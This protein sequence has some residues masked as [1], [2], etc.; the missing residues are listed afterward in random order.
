L[1][2]SSFLFVACTAPEPESRLKPP[3][4]DPGDDDDDDSGSVE[5]S[6]PET[7]DTAEVDPPIDCSALIPREAMTWTSSPAIQTEEDF[8]F[9]GQ[10]YLLTQRS[11]DIQG[12]DRFGGSHFVAANVGPDAT[13]IRSTSQGWV[14]V[15]QPHDGTVRLV[16]PSTGASRILASDLRSPNGLEAGEDGM[17]YVAENHPNGRVRMIDPTTDAI[18]TLAE[19]G[20][21]NGIVLSPDEL[22]LYFAKSTNG[23]SGSTDIVAIERDGGGTW[24]VN[25]MY[26]AYSHPGYVGSLTMDACGNLYGLEYTGKIFRLDTATGEAELVVNL[27]TGGWFT[28]LHFSPGLAGWQVDAVYVSDRSQLYEIPTGIPGSHVLTP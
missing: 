27:G 26:V 17:V 4:D 2:V 28:A 22:T 24:D 21:I 18:E 23:Y 15:A 20:F 19:P 16:D 13:G 14:A 8:D 5:S 25:T 12:I 11:N 10:G 3:Q 7:G 1:V 6:T 9:D